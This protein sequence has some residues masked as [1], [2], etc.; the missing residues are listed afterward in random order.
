M[1]VLVMNTYMYVQAKFLVLLFVVCDCPVARRFFFGFVSRSPIRP[2][3]HGGGGT[4]SV[5]MRARER[6]VVQ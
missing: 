5:M 1:S 3:W 6:S 4:G 2:S